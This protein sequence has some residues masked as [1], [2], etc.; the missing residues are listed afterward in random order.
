MMRIDCTNA[1]QHSSV[2]VRFKCPWV[3]AR[4]GWKEGIASLDLP[5]GRTDGLADGT[6][7]AVAA[8]R[9]S[10]LLAVRQSVR[11]H[12]SAQPA[13]LKWRAKRRCPSSGKNMSGREGEP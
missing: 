2:F 5:D 10:A 1:M 3:R 9:V 12:P 8:V 4:E 13:A 11:P 7:N 6:E